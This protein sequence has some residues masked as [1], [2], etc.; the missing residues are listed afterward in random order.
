MAFRILASTEGGSSST[1][2]LSE[3]S[4][5]NEDVFNI[6][7]NANVFNGT[8]NINNVFSSTINVNVFNGANNLNSRRYFRE[9]DRMHADQEMNLHSKSSLTLPVGLRPNLGQDDV[10]PPERLLYRSGGTVRVTRTAPS[11]SFANPDKKMQSLRP[12]ARDGNNFGGSGKPLSITLNN[13]SLE[14]LIPLVPSPN[15]ELS[16]ISADDSS[17]VDRN[18]LSNHKKSGLLQTEKLIDSNNNSNHNNNNNINNSCTSNNSSSTGSNMKQVASCSSISTLNEAS[19]SFKEIRDS[20]ASPPLARISLKKPKTE[21]PKL[22]SKTQSVFMKNSET[23]SSISATTSLNSIE[24]SVAKNVEPGLHDNLDVL[25]PV[26]AN[27]STRSSRKLSRKSRMQT[28]AHS[29]CNFNREKVLSEVPRDDDD[30]DGPAEATMTAQSSCSSSI[31]EAPLNVE[32]SHHY[33]VASI[34]RDMKLPIKKPSTLYLPMDKIFRDPRRK[35]ASSCTDI[36]QQSKFGRVEELI[37]ESLGGWCLF[38]QR[39]VAL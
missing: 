2:N 27:S 20:F 36:V 10:A 7:N 16:S 33:D 11:L 5:S 38:F 8:N 30:N 32:P 12:I 15:N 24:Q 29:E 39:N 37:N 22:A 6:S 23:K 18:A 25:I 21:K 28:R 9:S 34:R 31:S 26:V 35:F 3:T 14:F 17:F 1:L 4:P 13:Q 19:K